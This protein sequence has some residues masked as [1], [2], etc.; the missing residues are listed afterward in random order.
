MLAMSAMLPLSYVST[1]I[2]Q[3]ADVFK[4]FLYYFY[5]NPTNLR[6]SEK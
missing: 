6:K 3:A 4:Y 5:I 1:R 2:I